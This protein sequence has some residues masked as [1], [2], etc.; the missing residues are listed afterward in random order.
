[1]AGD[2]FANTTEFF[3]MDQRKFSIM[4]EDIEMDVQVQI[5]NIS[6]IF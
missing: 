4:L 5:G 3:S 6:L 2:R 1:M